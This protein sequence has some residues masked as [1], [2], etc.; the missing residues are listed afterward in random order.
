MGSKDLRKQGKVPTQVGLPDRNRVSLG[1]DQL[2]DFVQR[3]CGCPRGYNDT[4]QE[5]LH[6]YL[7]PMAFQDVGRRRRKGKRV[8]SIIS[9]DM[10]VDSGVRVLNPQERPN[11]VL[12][13]I[14]DP[15]RCNVA[16]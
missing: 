1:S 11:F 8:Y 10:S 2:I 12:V 15:L 14:F 13:S 5:G 7:S 3:G 16:K 9:V 6:I 4:R